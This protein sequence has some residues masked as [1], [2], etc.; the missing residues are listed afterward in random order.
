MDTASDARD[1][2]MD[3]P[4]QGDA[5]QNMSA[6]P[7]SRMTVQP[8]R[9]T[10]S[11]VAVSSVQPV[12]CSS[13]GLAWVMRIDLDRLIKS[14][15]PDFESWIADGRLHP[16]SA[17]ASIGDAG[18][19]EAVPVPVSLTGDHYL[20]LRSCVAIA[21]AMA[22][23]VPVTTEDI[24]ALRN[25]PHETLCDELR[26]LSGAIDPVPLQLPALGMMTCPDGTD[27]VW[28]TNPARV[29]FALS[30]LSGST[31]VRSGSAMIA[32]NMPRNITFDL[33]IPS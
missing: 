20:R 26:A 6:P 24:E 19:T 31:F 33:W 10:T 15:L 2:V 8:L 11:Q 12:S 18:K 27:R 14:H 1:D 21:R 3:T 4:G 7:K 29:F 30:R 9:P 25:L 32:G 13:S 22:G 17:A 5:L 23:A 16:G 28:E